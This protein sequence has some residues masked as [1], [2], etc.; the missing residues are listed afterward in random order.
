MR[1]LSVNVRRQYRCTRPPP[2]GRADQYAELPSM[3]KGALLLAVPVEERAAGVEK[4]LDEDLAL[5]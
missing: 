2:E 4:D 1:V 3:T 5:G